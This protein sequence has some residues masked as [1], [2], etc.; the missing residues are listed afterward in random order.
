MCDVQDLELFIA[1]VEPTEFEGKK[2][3][4]IGSRYVNGS[5]RPFIIKFLK[6]K[7]YVGIDLEPGK[8]VDIVMPVEELLGKFGPEAFDVIIAFNV[9]EHVK[10]WRIVI[11]N[12]K[13]VLKTNGILFISVPS[14]GFPYHEYPGDFWRY[15][16]ED[17][18]AIF[19]DFEIKVLEKKQ[20]TY[21]V[22]LKARK[23]ENFK[24]VDL[25][26]IALYSMCLGKRTKDIVDELTFTRKVKIKLKDFILN[27]GRNT[28]NA[29]F[30]T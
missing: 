13:N 15:Q 4:E 17:M 5:V 12:I 2:V 6:P 21:G 18:E 8:F 23:P 3:L 7:E 25:S 30:R 20:D 22:F 11:N 10:D 27:V 1:Y 24:A 9:L 16:L 26:N 28:L 19:S 14:I 29:I